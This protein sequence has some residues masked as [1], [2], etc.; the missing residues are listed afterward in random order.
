[1]GTFLEEPKF[2]RPPVYVVSVCFAAGKIQADPYNVSYNIYDLAFPSTKDFWFYNMEGIGWAIV[3]IIFGT[4]FFLIGLLELVSYYSIGEMSWNS[5]KYEIKRKFWKRLCTYAFWIVWCFYLCLFMAYVFLIL[6]WCILGAILYP[7]KFLALASASLVFIAFNARTYKTI[8]NF[9]NN[10]EYEVEKIIADHLKS[11]LAYTI[12]IARKE[13]KK[14]LEI[15]EIKFWEDSLNQVLDLWNFPKIDNQKLRALLEG[16]TSEYI[17]FLTNSFELSRNMSKIILGIIQNDNEKVKQGLR[18]IIK[19]LKFDNNICEPLWYIMFHSNFSEHHLRVRLK[20][21]FVRLFNALI[22]DTVPA[23]YRE[24]INILLIII[25]KRDF[26][27]F[28][29]LFQLKENLPLYSN[30]IF[31]T[32]D[33]SNITLLNSMFELLDDMLPPGAQA[34]KWLFS[35]HEDDLTDNCQAVCKMLGVDCAYQVMTVITILKENK[36]WS[37]FFVDQ[38]IDLTWE[39]FL[40]QENYEQ[41]VKIKGN[42]K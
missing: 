25:I 12:D 22:D 40:S 26:S 37:R 31:N 15:D 34:L 6:A 33:G 5:I 2:F 42:I 36:V 35:F 4:I 39:E 10:L 32:L 13:I 28:A 21:E 27:S 17:D 29:K 14:S 3:F 20:N 16:D 7:E 24:V 41:F 8:V 1:L 19:E 11:I 23:N 38:V 18:M 9:S 30:V